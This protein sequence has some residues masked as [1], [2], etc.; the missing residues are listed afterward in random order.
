MTASTS[1]QVLGDKVRACQNRRSPWSMVVEELEL[2]A[3][4]MAVPIYGA[5]GSTIAA[6]NLSTI[7]RVILQRRY[8]RNSCQN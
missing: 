3:F 8:S 2:G 1:I 6:I 5:N 7:W 4:G